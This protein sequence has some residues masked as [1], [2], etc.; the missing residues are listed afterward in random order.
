MDKISDILCGILKCK[1]RFSGIPLDNIEDEIFNIESM[2]G[3]LYFW[4]SSPIVK[5]E[6]ERRKEKIL[7]S[8]NDDNVKS[9]V[10]FIGRDQ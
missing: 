10:V 8:F 2:N 7:S 3:K 6:I 4:V 5:M 1:D 9:V